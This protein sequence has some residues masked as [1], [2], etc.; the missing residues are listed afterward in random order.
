LKVAR[1]GKA[2]GADRAAIRER[3]LRAVILADVTAPDLL[4][5]EASDLEHHAARY[6]ADFGRLHVHPAEFGE[7]L[8]RAR[9]GN[10]QQ[11]AVGVEEIVV[12]HVGIEGIGMRG[13]AGLRQRVARRRHRADALKEV[14]RFRGSR[15]RAPAQLPE[16]QGMLAHMRRCL[17]MRI[18]DPAEASG[19]ADA[20]SDPVE[21]GALVGAARCR[22][23]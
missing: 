5:S 9:F 11:L 6:E 16:R 14:Q 18:V 22:K 8:D 3:E 12:H 1:I 23:G 2:I 13:H 21:P 15:Q 19:V 7:N 10:D 4:L 17:P 20:R